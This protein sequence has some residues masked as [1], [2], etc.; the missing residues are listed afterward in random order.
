VPFGLHAWFFYFEFLFVNWNA[1]ES[2]FPD[3]NGWLYRPWAISFRSIEGGEN[4]I[5]FQ[6]KD[7][8]TDEMR[9]QHAGNL[10]GPEARST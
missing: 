8:T 3:M 5:Q 10:P 1:R 2:E 7:G 4:R 9:L 6:W